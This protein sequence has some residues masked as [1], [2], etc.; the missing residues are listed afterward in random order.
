MRLHFFSIFAVTGLS[1]MPLIQ[2]FGHL[3]FALKLKEFVHLREVA[4]SPQS[5]CPSRNDSVHFVEAMI[6]QVVALHLGNST[7]QPRMA[8]NGS[9]SET[10]EFLTPNFTHLHIGCDEVYHMSE[11]QRCK[12]RD[13]N[14]LFVSHVRNVANIVRRRWPTL[15]LVIWDDMLRQIQLIDLQKS[16]LGALVEPMVWV[17]AEDI[18]RFVSMQ[19][20]DK[21]AQVFPTVW[22]ASAFK[23][24]HGETLSLPPA[25]RHLENNMQWLTVINAE[26]SRFTKGIMGLAL[27][28]WQRYDHFAVLCELLPVAIPSLAVSLSTVSKGYFDTEIRHNHLLA[29]LTCSEPSESQRLRR[30]WLEM[31]HDPELLSFAKCMFPGSQTL[32]YV[33]RLTNT[34][35]DVR[36]YLDNINYKR[37]WLT[38]YNIRH[39]FSS[40]IRIDELVRDAIRFD[41]SLTALAKSAVESLIDIFDKW[42]IDEYIEQ[43][44][45]PLLDALQKLQYHA[46]QL[47]T[48][49]VW[50]RRPLPTTHTRKKA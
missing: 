5:L 46:K 39:N 1:V 19:T 7:H 18:Y 44:I 35:T 37:G 14:E 38:A 50:P 43:T 10:S 20:W 33:I 8:T 41:A 29:A 49:R 16:Q 2:T 23:G 6:E 42:T 22:T 31:V 26:K 12:P 15:N 25:R 47:M 40:S 11:C 30:P 21:Y 4:E 27:T 36:Q 34:I 13:R 24:A 3:E 45:T 17:Y 28:G 48:I 32:R 9:T